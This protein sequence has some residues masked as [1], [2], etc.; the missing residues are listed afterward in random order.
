[1][2][3]SGIGLNSPKEGTDCRSTI[4]D[5]IPYP[6]IVFQSEPDLNVAGKKK[7]KL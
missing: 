3:A 2:V 6:D 4:T 5:V 7:A 1:M